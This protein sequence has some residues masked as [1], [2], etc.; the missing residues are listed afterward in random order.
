MILRQV[1]LDTLRFILGYIAKYPRILFQA[2]FVACHFLISL[3]TLALH[4]LNL[5]TV[6]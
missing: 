6:S 4:K 3:Y 1:S 2:I 5:L